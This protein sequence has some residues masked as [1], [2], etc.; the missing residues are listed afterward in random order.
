MYRKCTYES[1]AIVIES[2]FAC[3]IHLLALALQ[4]Q[5]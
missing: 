1:T 3:F 4:A 5:R 2:N